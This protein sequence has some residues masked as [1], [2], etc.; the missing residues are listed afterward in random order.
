MED[1]VMNEV[2]YYLVTGGIVIQK[3]PYMAEGYIEGP[4]YVVAGYLYSNG[5][6]TP[7][8]PTPID[9]FEVNTIELERL[10]RLANSQVTALQGRV[11]ALVDAVD[12]DIATDEEIAEQSVRAAQLKAWKTYRVLLGRVTSQAEWPTNPIWPV[13]PTPYTSETSA[14]SP[15]ENLS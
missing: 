14:I 9:Y 6:F 13:V 12:L 7:P 11:D 15:T 8:P 1:I 5:E 2:W 3:Q 4:S 10:Q